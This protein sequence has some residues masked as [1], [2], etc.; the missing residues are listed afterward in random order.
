MEPEAKVNEHS[1]FDEGSTIAE[2]ARVGM[3]GA[4]QEFVHAIRQNRHPEPGPEESLESQ[5][6]IEQAYRQWGRQGDLNDPG[7]LRFPG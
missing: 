1:F 3:K 6:I 5:A 7:P 4:L 2:R